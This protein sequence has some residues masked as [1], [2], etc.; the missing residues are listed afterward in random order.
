MFANLKYNLT[1]NW[2]TFRVMRMILAVIAIWQWIV[3]GDVIMGLAGL[4]IA[5]QAIANISCAGGNCYLPNS[6]NKNGASTESIHFEE[7]K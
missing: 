5:Y 2:T 6:G 7:I 4:I 1:H 3:A